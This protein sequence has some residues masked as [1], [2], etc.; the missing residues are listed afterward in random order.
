MTEHAWV[1]NVVEILQGFITKTFEANT[2][3]HG[4]ESGGVKLRIALHL[5]S[6]T[7]SY[8]QTLSQL[9]AF[10]GGV[11]TA[12]V[13]VDHSNDSSFLVSDDVFQILGKSRQYHFASGSKV[14]LKD[15]S[16]VMTY[17]LMDSDS[18]VVLGDLSKDLALNGTAT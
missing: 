9:I 8:V 16:S 13:L 7:I 15:K 14:R 1:A 18:S 5:G 17:W 3:Y 10:G 4:E 11:E 12:K 2:K 6:A